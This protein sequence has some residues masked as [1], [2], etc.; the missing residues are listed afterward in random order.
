MNKVL[1]NLD[2]MCASKKN[3]ALFLFMARDFAKS[4]YN[5]SS[6]KRVRLIYLQSKH[7]ICERCGSPNARQVHH[8]EYL[9]EENINNNNI[10]LNFD[11]LECLCDICHQNEHNEKTS[12]TRDD[13][14]FD[15][16][17]QL[18]K[19][20]YPPLKNFN[21]KNSK[22]RSQTIGNVIGDF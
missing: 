7:Y 10:A 22:D 11:N 15:D 13:V 19:K 12:I 8:K 21:P 14:E 20:S 3:G 17:G 6:W 16:N 4:F 9:T 2:A 5:S 18:I 1:Y